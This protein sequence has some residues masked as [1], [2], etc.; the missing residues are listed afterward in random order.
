MCVLSLAKGTHDLFILRLFVCYYFF[1]T[2]IRCECVRCRKTEHV[3]AGAGTRG[4]E[5]VSEKESQTSQSH[6]INEYFIDLIFL[7]GSQHSDLDRTVY[8]S[9]ILLNWIL[10]SFS[11]SFFAWCCRCR[12]FFLCFVLEFASLLRKKC[13]EP[14]WNARWL[15]RWPLS[16]FVIHSSCTHTPVQRSKWLN[17]K[18]NSRRR[19][20]KCKNNN[21]SNCMSSS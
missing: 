16:S 13:E 12:R 3:N 19:Q 21:K 14:N 9:S 15:I 7:A 18:K 5:W 6:A 8:K 4:R 10:C 17:E 20:N 11:F 2:M 1:A